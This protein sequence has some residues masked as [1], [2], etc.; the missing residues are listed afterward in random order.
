M[1]YNTTNGTTATSTNILPTNGTAIK[2]STQADAATC[3]A[4][5]AGTSTAAGLYLASGGRGSTTST[6]SWQWCDLGY[7][8]AYQSGTIELPD[9]NVALT[10]QPASTST[11][12]TTSLNTQFRTAGTVTAGQWTNVGSSPG[13]MTDVYTT[14]GGFAYFNF[15]GNLGYGGYLTLTNFGFTDADVPVA[16]AITG[17]EVQVKYGGF[18]PLTAPSTIPLTVKSV[19]LI[20]VSGSDQPDLGTPQTTFKDAASG[21]SN[22]QTQGGNYNFRLMDIGAPASGSIPPGRLG[23]NGIAASDIKAS[24]FGLKLEIA[25]SPV[26]FNQNV[27]A[28][29]DYVKIRF[30]YLPAG[31]GIYFWN[32]SCVCYPAGGTPSSGLTDGVT[33]AA[34]TTVTSA[35][36]NFVVRGVTAGMVVVI[37]GAGVAAATLVTTVASVTD[38]THIVLTTAPSTA[39]AA[40]AVIKIYQA[41]VHAQIVKHYRLSGTNGASTAAGSVYLQFIQSNGAVGGPP[42][43]AIAASE[44]IRSWPG[45]NVQADG[46]VLDSSIQYALTSSTHNQNTMDWSALLAGVGQP[47]GSTAPASKYQSVTKNFYASTGLEGIYGVSGGG[48][49]FYYDGVKADASGNSVVGNFSR[50]LTGLPT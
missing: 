36:G 30:A 19:S 48:P 41:P 38:A 33:V 7:N 4:G 34:N 21:A 40:N 24:T 49:A 15:N 13:N 29:V 23:Y 37:P 25:T 50:I 47:D 46:G 12:A 1:V 14:D 44:Q 10:N 20:G 45:G 11:T 43:R 5:A 35:T 42:A 17:I 27:Y 9:M 16:S 6:A 18:W 31:N 3:T 2:N 28:G 8:I 26:T 32:P 22:D 39:I